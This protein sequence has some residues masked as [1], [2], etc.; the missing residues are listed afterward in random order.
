MRKNARSLGATL[1]L[2]AALCA[3]GGRGATSPGGASVLPAYGARSASVPAAAAS[4]ES[5]VVD[6]AHGFPAVSEDLIGASLATWS[7]VTQPYVKQTF[8]S[9]GLRSVRWPGGSESD[10]YHWQNGGTICD[11]QGYVYPASTF[12][13]FMNDAAIPAKLDVSLTL[14]YGSNATCDGGGDPAEAAAWVS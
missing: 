11:G 14:N 5:I 13:N 12:D 10:A 9:T 7:D 2:G 1:L 4:P 3:C 8:I 6:A